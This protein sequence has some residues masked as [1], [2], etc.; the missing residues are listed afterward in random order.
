VLRASIRAVCALRLREQRN[1]PADALVEELRGS[2]IAIE[3]AAANAQHYEVPP[4]F[5]ER[6]LGPHLKYSSCYWPDGVTSLASAEHAMLELTAER[7][8]LEDGQDVLDLGCGWGS[9]SLWAAAKY[10]ASRFT[11]ISNSGPQ[12]THIEKLARERGLAN[13]TVRTADVRQLELP[14]A[15]FDRIVSIEMFEHMRNYAVLLKRIA[16]WLVPTGQLFV[17]VFAHRRYAY[18]FTDNGASDWMAREFFTGG[19]MPSVGLFRHFQEDLVICDEWQLDGTHYAKTAEAWHRN[20]LAHRAEIEALL[21]KRAFQRW[22]VFFLACAELFG[23][24]K[25]REWLVA[26][27]RFA[28]R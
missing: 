18:P 11:A 22:R 12:R 1:A 24:A 14:A 7:A 16:S 10:P 6:V 28:P 13:L 23:Y 25:G 26:H 27:Y 8:G 17:H 3:T 5:F 19:L 15:R 20:L 21:G 4:A 2:E 9:F